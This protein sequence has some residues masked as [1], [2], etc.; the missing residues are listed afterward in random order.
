M[1]NRCIITFEGLNVNRF[2]NSL[3]RQ[4]MTV[5]NVVKRGRQCILQVDAIHSQKVVAQLKEKCYNIIDVR[6]TGVSFGLQFAKTRFI[7]II[8]IIL[9]ALILAISSQ[10]CLRI[11]TNG[12]FSDE[13]VLSALSESGIKVGTSLVG[14]NPDAVENAVANRLNAM[15]A[16]VNRRGSVI[17]V[18]AVASKQ[19]DAPI[20]MSKRRDIVSNVEGVVTAVLCEQ[21]SLLVNVGDYVKIGDVLIEGKRVFN[22]G[23]SRDVY[24]LGRVT[25][26]QSVKSSVVFGGYKTEQQ[27]TGNSCLKVGVVILG[28]QY[29]NNCMYDSYFVDT[30]YKYLDPLNIAIVYNTYYETHSVT[31]ACDLE[32]CLDEL[33]RQ[34]YDEARQKCSFIPQDVE[35]TAQGNVVTATLTSETYIQ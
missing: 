24:A 25:I 9:C 11:E 18:N 31:V 35:F 23:E 5:L 2:I 6:Y 12:D 17:Y 21:G 8:S 20:D 16:V 32:D 34:A 14:F 27:P 29:V 1:N 10:F 22:D 28:K 13:D 26:R 7:L 19:I 15:Y 30:S 4:N 33:K 3:C